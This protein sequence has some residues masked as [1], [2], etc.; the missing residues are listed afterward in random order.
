MSGVAVTADR[1][2]HVQF[3]QSYLDE[4]VAFI[5]LDH[6]V[7]KFA[8]WDDVR[9][10]GRIRVGMPRGP[11]FEQ[12]IRDEL[13]D[14]EVVPIDGMDALFEPHQPP[15]DALV[16]TAER[17]SAYTIL[18]PEFSVVVPKPRPMKVPLAY[19][20]AGRDAMMTGIVNTWID[21]KRKDGTIDELFAHWILG[22][23]TEAVEPRWSVVRNVLHLVP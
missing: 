1:A 8:E 10:M 20:V 21:L 5:V 15:F 7:S 16:G 3:S 18:H 11:Y 14:A 6:L 19:V 9:R 4:T 22:R 17:G 13:P 12:K 2:L 23:Q